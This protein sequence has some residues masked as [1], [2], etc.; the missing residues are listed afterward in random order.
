MNEGDALDPDWK[1]SFYGENY[2][3]LLGVKN[4]YDPE[5]VFYCPTCVGSDMWEADGAGRLCRAS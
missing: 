1:A 5:S 4:V 2:D 3:K